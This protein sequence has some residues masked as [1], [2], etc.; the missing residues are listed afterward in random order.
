MK[1]T[2]LLILLCSIFSFSNVLEKYDSYVLDDSDVEMSSAY[3]GPLITTGGAM[4][5][6]SAIENMEPTKIGSVESNKITL[7]DEP[8]EVYVFDFVKY[9]QVTL[10][11][12]TFYVI[13]I[14]SKM[15]EHSY[16]ILIELKDGPN[17]DRTM[18]IYENGKPKTLI[19]WVENNRL[20]P[21][22]NRE[23]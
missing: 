2:L 17:Y 4:A 9:Y 23:I 8:N 11:A 1:K 22:K 10:D 21:K 15:N 20:T 7:I 5:G 6:I 13:K 18:N 12:D 19:L 14:D 3:T 16:E